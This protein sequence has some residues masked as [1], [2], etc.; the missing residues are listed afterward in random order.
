MVVA[1]VAAVAAAVVVGIA[2]TCWLPVPGAW[3]DRCHISSCF[4]RPG[5]V[6]AAFAVVAAVGP[7]PHYCSN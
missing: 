7:L 1:V 5:M 3:L 2:V 4:R 6:D